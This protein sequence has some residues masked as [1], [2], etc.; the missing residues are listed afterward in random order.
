MGTRD[1]RE[2]QR[3][4]F[5]SGQHK[6]ILMTMLILGLMAFVPVGM[7]LYGL[8]VRDNAYYARKALGNQTRSTT[9]TGDRGEIYDRNMNILA[10]SVGV[11]NV[12][13]D[14]H[15]LK[16]AK[17]NIQEIAQFLETSGKRSTVDCRTGSGF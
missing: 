6:R 17:E 3:V 2:F 8:M 11:E 12:Y 7:Q 1:G 13:L 4:R 5:D 10:T 14:P 15:E 16:Q 9:V